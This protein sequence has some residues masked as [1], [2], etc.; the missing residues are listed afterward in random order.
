M[1][2]EMDNLDQLYILVLVL[3][4]KHKLDMQSYLLDSVKETITIKPDLIIWL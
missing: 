1:Q 2:G 4:N 3:K